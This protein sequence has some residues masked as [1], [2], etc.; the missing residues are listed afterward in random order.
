MHF[1]ADRVRENAKR[2]DTPDLLDRV[3]VYRAEIDERAYPIII[4]ELR[5]RGITATDVMTHEESRGEHLKHPA[6]YVQKCSL[7]PQPAMTTA[8]GWF[9]LFGLVPFIPRTVYLCQTHAP[10]PTPAS[11]SD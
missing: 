4:Q 5:T 2:A 3:T 1:D 7:C 10:Q 8:R 6:G 9:R 11:A